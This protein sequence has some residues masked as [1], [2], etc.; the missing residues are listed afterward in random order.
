ME[1]TMTKRNRIIGIDFLKTMA[2][3]FVIVLH[4][5]GYCVEQV[6]GLSSY[7]FSSKVVYLLLE[8]VAYPAIHLFVLISSWFMVGKT[9]TMKSCVKVYSQTWT[10]TVL[11]LFIAIILIPSDIKMG[12]YCKAFSLSHR[13]LIGLFLII[14]F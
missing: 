10:V 5:N 12:G 1:N 11:G 3:I 2:V 14:L 9:S 7:S 8:A 4:V 13:E 6:G